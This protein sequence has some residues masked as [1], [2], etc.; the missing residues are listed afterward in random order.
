MGVGQHLCILQSKETAR[1]AFL[2]NASPSKDLPSPSRILSV[3]FL[4]AGLLFRAEEEG[5]P[6]QPASK[7][8]V[9]IR[10]KTS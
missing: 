2:G 4:A 6:G 5:G 9:L 1:I 10:V 8:Y 3:G 7:A